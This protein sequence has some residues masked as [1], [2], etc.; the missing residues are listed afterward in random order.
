MSKTV[1][2]YGA[3]DD[4]LEVYGDIAGA[5]EY[6]AYGGPVMGTLT[7]PDGDSLIVR[8]EYCKPGAPGEWTLSIEN[9]DTFPDWPIKFGERPNRD[10]DPALIIEVPEGTVFKFE[11]EDED[12]E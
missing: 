12:H 11:Q 2:I 4:L 9:T 8:A 5:D 1:T 6:G 7:S 10:G 3:S